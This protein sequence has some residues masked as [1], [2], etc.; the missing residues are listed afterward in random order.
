MSINKIKHF[1][2]VLALLVASTSVYARS[3]CNDLG[4][5]SSSDILQ[6]PSLDAQTL[7]NQAMDEQEIGNKEAAEYLLQQA[8]IVDPTF[9][10]IKNSS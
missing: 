5:E 10:G 2:L 7:F 1:A 8:L 9:M 6:Q 4:H 3:G